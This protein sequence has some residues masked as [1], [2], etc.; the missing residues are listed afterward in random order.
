MTPTRDWLE[1]WSGSGQRLVA[2]DEERL[3]E[4][5]QADDIYCMLCQCYFALSCDEASYKEAAKSR[6][7]AS[8]DHKRG[9][10]Q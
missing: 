1:R 7:V 8:E 2:E 10:P 4:L 9:G 6:H 5:R 3:Y